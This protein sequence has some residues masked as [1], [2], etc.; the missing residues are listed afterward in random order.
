[1]RNPNRYG[2][3]VKLSGNRSR[4][5]MVRS[6]VR[7]YDDRG[8][9]IFDI[10]GYTE[11]RE[12]GNILLAEYNQDPWDVQRSKTTLQE[13]FDLWCE[14]KAPKLGQSNRRSLISVYRF[15]APLA[16]KPYRQIK[17]YQMQ[18]CI[19]T[20][21]KSYSTQAT[22]KNLWRH[23]DRFA[24][25]L[26]IAS[27]GYSELLSSDPIPL[28][29]KRPFTEQELQK[30]WTHSKDPWA[31]SV[32][33]LLYSGW[34]IGE[35]LDLKKQYVDVSNW[36][37]T[38]GSKTAA[39]KNR[40]VP[41]HTRIQP[42]VAAR[43]EQPG[44]YLFGLNGKGCSKTSY[45]RPWSELMKAWGMDHTPHECRHTFRTRLDSAG[46]NQKCCDMLMGHASKDVG[47]RV[48]NHKTIAELRAAI[49]LL[50]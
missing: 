7:G 22:I 20:C 36:T 42:L 47:N 27:R 35:L 11:T 21:G 17:A 39:G 50:S 40:I 8:Y 31:D 5:Y 6:G 10:L 46:A 30:V 34:R 4:P 48:Y 41:I 15:C 26:D 38:G 24:L 28:S 33:V 44:D 29:S 43:M 45:R 25:E 12:A 18:E 37:M 49:E 3:V 16:S 19:D 32:L 2:S 9:P 1:M 14:K 13:L 23:L